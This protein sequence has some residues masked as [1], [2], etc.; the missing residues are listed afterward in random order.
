MFFK[1]DT[2]GTVG[3][4]GN[5]TYLYLL[6]YKFLWKFTGILFCLESNFYHKK[7]KKIIK[8]S[9][10]K[11]FTLGWLFDEYINWIY[12]KSPHSI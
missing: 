4:A 11:L 5:H 1:E 12:E 3:T 6:N 8:I 2:K 7:R 9:N 10:I